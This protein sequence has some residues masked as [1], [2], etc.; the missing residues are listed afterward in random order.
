MLMALFI[1]PSR[2]FARARLSHEPKGRPRDQL[3]ALPPDD[4]EGRHP[5]E[6]VAAGAAACQ[7]RQPEEGADHGQVG[8]VL[9]NGISVG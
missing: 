8:D 7:H 2:P 4:H 9:R 5:A 3:A 6:G 1:S